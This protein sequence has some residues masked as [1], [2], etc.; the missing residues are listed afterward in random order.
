M[1]FRS[2]LPGANNLTR[3]GAPF[4]F[5]ENEMKKRW[6][7]ERDCL[8]IVDSKRIVPLLENKVAHQMFFQET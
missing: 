5:G 8:E 1:G 7:K 2:V 6:C 4:F 3:L